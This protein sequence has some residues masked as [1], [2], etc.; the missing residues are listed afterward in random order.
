M[1]LCAVSKEKGGFGRLVTAE[2]AS[3][4]VGI[5]VSNQ[6]AELYSM[7]VGKRLE[8][9]QGIWCSGY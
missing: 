3:S 4:F 8:G 2:V 5:G 7:Q 6:R 1:P 9:I